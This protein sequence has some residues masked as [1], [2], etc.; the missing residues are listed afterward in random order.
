MYV[1]YVSLVMLAL[2]MVVVSACQC[3]SRG[4][5]VVSGRRGAW[6]AYGVCGTALIAAGMSLQVLQRVYGSVAASLD[7]CT[8]AVV[9]ITAVPFVMLGAAIY[10]LLHGRSL[11]RSVVFYNVPRDVIGPAVGRVLSRMGLPFSHRLGTLAEIYRLASGE[12]IIVHGGGIC[13]RL[14]MPTR[15]QAERSDLVDAVV[16][17][18]ADT[19]DESSHLLIDARQP[20]AASA[21]A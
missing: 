3:R 20:A 15:R 4:R 7:N 14:E 6:V 12:R 2:A 21:S 5:R 16:Q 13:S 9:L 10:A 11:S 18:V 8:T 17:E 19:A 1:V